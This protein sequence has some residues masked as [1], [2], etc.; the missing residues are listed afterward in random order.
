MLAL[1]VKEGDYVTI[2]PDIVVQVLK[3]GE[4]FRIAIDAPK[5]LDIR[6]GKVHEELE[7]E[8]PKAIQKVRKK[9]PVKSRA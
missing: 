4:Q 2:G 5:S 7:G 8:A 3:V 6:R 1:S 9:A